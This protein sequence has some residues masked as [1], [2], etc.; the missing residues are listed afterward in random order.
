MLRA[1]L[2]GGLAVWVDDRPVPEIGGVKPRSL[3]AYLL[4]N[5]GT[6]PRAR[7]AGRFWPDVLDTSARGSLRSALWAIRSALEAAG[8]GPLLVADRLGAGI[9]PAA[10]VDVDAREVERLFALGDEASLRRAVLLGAEPLLPDIPDEWVL[11]A[12][13]RHRDRMI[14]ALGALAQASEAAGDLPRALSFS[15]EALARDRLR[16]SSHRALMRRLAAAGDRGGALAA[17]RRCRDTLAAELG[18]V[19]SAETRLL[20]DE[21]RA[22]APVSAHPLRRPAASSPRLRPTAGAGMVGREGELA[23]C[24]A[25]W[26][27][28]ASG[29]GGMLLIEGAAGAGKS[30]LAVELRGM[31]STA[32]GRTATGHA[33]DIEE[34]PPFGPWT[35]ALRQLVRASEAPPRAVGWPEDLARL[36]PAV[37]VAW[38]RHPAHAPREPALG[39]VRLFEAVAEALEWCARG[40]PVLVLLE[41]LHRADPS[42]LALLAHLGLS[43]QTAPVLVVVTAR[44]GVPADGLDRAREAL[45][46]RG[47]LREVVTLAPLA[48]EEV[49]LIVRRESPGIDP[50][51]LA[52]VTA[53]AEGNPLLALHAARAAAVGGDPEEGLRDAVRGPLAGLSPEARELVAAAAAAGRALSIAEAV[54]LMGPDALDDAVAEGITC[55]LL[56][57]VSGAHVAFTHDLVRRACYGELPAGRRRAAHAR[58]ARMM[59]AEPGRPPAEVAHHLRGAGDDE[60]ARAYLVAAAS[61]ARALGALGQAATYLTDAAES[62]AVANSPAGEA[63]AWLALAEIEAWRGDQPRMDAAFARVRALLTGAGDARGLA[64][65]LAERARWLRTT[66]CYPEEAIRSSREAVELL[67]ASGV[68]APETRLLAMAGMAWGEAVSGDP[69]HARRMLVE[70][71]AR[72]GGEDDVLRAELVMAGGFALV[73]SG[74]GA[75][76]RERCREA[77]TI[78]DVAGRPALALDARIAEAACAAALGLIPDVLEVLSGAPDPART[79]PGLACQSWA[80]VAHAL[81]RLDRHEAAVDA[82]REEVRVAER[83]GTSDLEAAAAADLGLVLLA[84]G[85][86]GEA[87][88]SLEACLAVEDGR[89]PRAALRLAATEAALAAGDLSGARAHLDRFPFEPVGPGDDPAGLIARLDRVTGL[90]LLAEGQRAP[91]LAHLAAAAARWKR[92]LGGGRPAEQAGR[93]LLSGMIDLGR[94]PVAGLSDPA[95]ELARVR[96]EHDRASAGVLA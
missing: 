94:P 42:T 64:A 28:A 85:R 3:L 7:L 27:A 20:A 24:R 8:G 60:R 56:D 43:L 12:Q 29:R 52:Q 48:T 41:D 31:A 10:E 37:E 44:S 61:A 46:R 55:G 83:F 53:A 38:E 26:D 84:A 81:S 73:R 88:E 45:S 33:L 50:V 49:A 23:R 71:E 93:E 18:M 70:V 59:S 74:E 89:V 2:F 92:L 14:E 90:V 63:E 32:G 95:R 72:L 78:A 96:A 11:D 66:T 77:A 39:Q 6:H 82:A 9:D 62:A 21:I 17:F 35:D 76:A 13:D 69:A 5:A 86:P 68:D 67:D 57:P 75:A 58:L 80:G 1:R 16:E 79:G 30:R 22:G 4:V 47:G 91:G 25:A 51:A 87:R 40:S 36:C 65:A 34:R 15:R 54:S 19:P